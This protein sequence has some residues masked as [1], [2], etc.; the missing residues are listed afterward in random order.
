MPKAPVNTVIQDVIKQ[1]FKKMA[2]K[3]SAVKTA[4]NINYNLIQTMDVYKKL[5]K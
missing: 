4:K 5:N 1:E 3:N 2:I